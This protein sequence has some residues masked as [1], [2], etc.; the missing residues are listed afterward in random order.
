MRAIRAAE[1]FNNVIPSGLPTD[2]RPADYT[3][4]I[5]K[6]PSFDGRRYPLGKIKEILLREHKRLE[7]PVNSLTEIESMDNSTVFVIAGQQAGLFGGY[8]YTTYKALHAIKLAARLSADTGKNVLPLF[9]VA[10][11]DH[12]ADEISHLGTM[13]ESIGVV[14]ITYLPV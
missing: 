14:T 4:L 2:S 1:L 8:L 3:S 12:D 7:S 6:T 5:S 11:D 10:T 9:W 13:S